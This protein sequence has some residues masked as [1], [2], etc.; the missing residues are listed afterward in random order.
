MSLNLNIVGRRKPGTTIADHRHHIRAV[1]GEMVLRFIEVA[2][3]CAPHRYVQNAVFDGQYRTTPPGTDPFALNRDF[4]TQVWVDDFAMLEASRRHPF[5]NASLKDDEDNF[6]DQAT[7]VF[8]PSRE[9]Q[10]VARGDQPPTS[11]KL[12]TLMRRA[13]DADPGDY[14]KAWVDA[15]GAAGT[16][17]LR[18]VQNDVVALPGAAPA[19][20]AIDEFWLPNEADA[21]RFLAS[22]SAVLAD[23]LVKPG[24]ACPGG[25]VA[26]LAREDVVHAGRT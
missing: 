13:A 1:H 9:R 15:A 7:V 24:L 8:L 26:L 19:A 16:L 6:V 25:V 22:W 18:H 12:F 4:V 5:Y 2:P 20:D 11:V 10:I 23:K 3:D 21:R 17:P 14:A